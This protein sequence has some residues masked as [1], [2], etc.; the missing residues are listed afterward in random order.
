MLVVIVAMSYMRTT[1]SV[2]GAQA[3]IGKRNS[4]STLSNFDKLMLATMLTP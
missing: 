4:I 1:L 2:I 3:V